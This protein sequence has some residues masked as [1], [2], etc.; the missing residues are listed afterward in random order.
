[1]TD[2][3]AVR[4]KDRC[5]TPVVAAHWIRQ[6]IYGFRRP[7][8]RLRPHPSRDID[9]LN[10]EMVAAGSG[11]SS[12]ASPA[13]SA[14]SL[15]RQPDG[16]VLITGGPYLETKEHLGSFHLLHLAKRP[17]CP[18]DSIVGEVHATLWRKRRRCE[19]RRWRRCAGG[20]VGEQEVAFARV[21]S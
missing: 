20:G 16:K 17:H 2:K 15:R 1:M 3:G 10:E 4:C 21:L 13:G 12:A 8:R 5:W 11:S 19:L 18:L 6:V 9:A 7:S 14:R